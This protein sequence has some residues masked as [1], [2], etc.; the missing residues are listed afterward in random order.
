[1]RAKRAERAALALLAALTAGGAHA[2]TTCNVAA[3]PVAFGS[4]SMPSASAYDGVGAVSV[5]CSATTLPLAL[6]TFTASLGTSTG[7]G[8][9]TR[10]LTRAGGGTLQYQL[11]RDTSRTQVWGDGSGGTHTAGGTVLLLLLNQQATTTL[12]VFGRIPAGQSPASG[13]YSDSVTVTVDY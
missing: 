3:Q 10:A 13:A 11:Y 12:T 4:L 6:I 9:F 2:A 1:M 7:S 8:S 5:T